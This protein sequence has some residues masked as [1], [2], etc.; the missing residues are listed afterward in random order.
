[1][2]IVHDWPGRAVDEIPSPALVAAWLALDMVPTE[3][4]PRWAAFG[5]ADGHDGN[6][7]VDLAGLRGD[8]PHEVRDVLAAALAGFGAGGQHCRQ[9]R[10]G[11]GDRAVADAFDPRLL[12]ICGARL[13][14]VTSSA[15]VL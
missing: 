5:L 12:S 8:D 9:D 15:P 13:S 1:M 6:G 7:L 3:K 14:T 10:A 2:D 4:I 11:R